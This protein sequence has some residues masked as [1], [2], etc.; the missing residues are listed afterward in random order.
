[1]HARLNIRGLGKPPSLVKGA[2]RCR[3]V[4]EASKRVDYA[5]CL[6]NLEVQLQSCET[7]IQANRGEA[8]DTLIHIIK[9]AARE[10]GLVE[11]AP[12]GTSGTKPIRKPF[13][14]RDCE[15]LKR[16]WRRQGQHLGHRPPE[17]LTLKRKYHSHVPPCK[18]RWIACTIERSHPTIPLPFQNV[19]ETLN[20]TP[21]TSPPT[22][23]GSPTMAWVHT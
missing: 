5:L 11:K 23:T 17:V 10:A 14:D 20:R 18:R 13:Y 21:N 15:Q 4:W 9:T 12:R 19:L 6:E 16:E 8:V 2:P 22:L 1:L 7:L 3:V